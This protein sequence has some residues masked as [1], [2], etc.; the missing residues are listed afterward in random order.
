MPENDEISNN[1][2][3]REKKRAFRKSSIKTDEAETC[4][5]TNCGVHI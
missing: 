2:L 1:N 3:L 5:L 4:T